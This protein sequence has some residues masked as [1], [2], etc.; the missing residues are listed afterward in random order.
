MSDAAVEGQALA[1]AL[2][3]T[4]EELVRFTDTGGALTLA[5]LRAWRGRVRP[6]SL[7][8]RTILADAVQAMGHID[9]ALG[10]ISGMREY[11]SPYIYIHV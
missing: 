4:Q 8:K 9:L 1:K 5:V 2:G 7:N 11:R 6:P 10:I 3:F